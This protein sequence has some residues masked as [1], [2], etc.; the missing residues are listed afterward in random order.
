MTRVDLV[1]VIA[2][3]RLGSD[4]SQ[5]NPD[6]LRRSEADEVVN[7]VF[8]AIVEALLKGETVEL[9]IGTFKVQK[10]TRPTPSGRLL[11]IKYEWILMPAARPERTGP[12]P[13]P[14]KKKIRKFK[15]YPREEQLKQML[16][17]S[18]KWIVDQGL[19]RDQVIYGLLPDAK[20]WLDL[21]RGRAFREY[22]LRP[23][24][25]LL[26]TRPPNFK[27]NYEML[28]FCADWFKS[29][30]A[31][32]APLDESLREEVVDTLIDWAKSTLPLPTGVRPWGPKRIHTFHQL[33]GWRP[34]W[35]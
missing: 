34:R 29:F 31:H 5:W 35:S 25:L 27:E 13:I 22:P 9:P 18:K 19:L 26:K 2:P 16:K 11:K 12:P 24:A 33:P 10:R 3:N 15:R 8:E 21:N 23:A 17:T 14:R 4:K 32:C 1:D 7:V 28:A 30:L 20:K 6:V